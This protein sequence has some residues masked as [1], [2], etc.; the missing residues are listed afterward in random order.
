MLKTTRDG[1]PICELCGCTCH[2]MSAYADYENLQ[3]YYV[4]P[5]CETDADERGWFFVTTV[6]PISGDHVSF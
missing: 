3:H 5:D 6:F 4:C 2:E 1:Q